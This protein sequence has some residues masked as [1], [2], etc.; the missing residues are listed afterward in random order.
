MS[1][2]MYDAIAYAM[3][4]WFIFVVLGI[5]IA[6]I[7]ISVREVREKR[8]ALSEVGSYLGYLEIVGGPDE[9][10]GDRFGLRDQNMIGSGGLADIL[11][12][13][14][15]KTHGYI[16]RQGEDLIFEPETK[17]VAK[18]NGRR[19]TNPHALKTGDVVTLGDVELRVY[20]KRTRVRDDS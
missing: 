13:T 8:Q 20:L 6:M 17:R 19:A 4:Y 7:V 2:A 12:P 9:Y 11:I 3:R 18:I 15:A 5:L 1:S 10:W 16:Y 14:I